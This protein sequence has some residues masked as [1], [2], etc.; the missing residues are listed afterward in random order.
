[1]FVSGLHY[2]H[3][4]SADFFRR[5]G[6]KKSANGTGKDGPK[7]ECELELEQKW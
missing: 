4:K 3:D 1:V 2:V 7:N 6:L 5:L